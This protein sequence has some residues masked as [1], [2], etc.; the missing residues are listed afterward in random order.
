MPWCVWRTIIFLSGFSL[1]FSVLSYNAVIIR[2]GPQCSMLNSPTAVLPLPSA[3]LFQF[4]KEQPTPQWMTADC[5][6]TPSLFRSKL[7]SS[8]KLPTYE[9]GCNQS[10]VSSNSC[11]PGRPHFLPW[12]AELQATDLPLAQDWI[13]IFFKNSCREDKGKYIGGTEKIVKLVFIPCKS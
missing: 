3:N 6:S 1:S 4:Q 7:V 5:S 11:G 13:F 9:H 8:K 12:G 2:V 10:P